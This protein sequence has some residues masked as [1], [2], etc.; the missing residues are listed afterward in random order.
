MDTHLSTVVHVSEHPAKACVMSA[1]KRTRRRIM[2]L[3]KSQ[4]HENP[5]SIRSQGGDQGER[6][7]GGDA[8]AAVLEKLA[9][10]H[11]EFGRTFLPIVT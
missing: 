6:K 1:K 2:Y 3:V 8:A 7:V 5:S 10:T 4:D 11:V 9:E